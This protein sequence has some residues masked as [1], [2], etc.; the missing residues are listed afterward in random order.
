MEVELPAPPA[1][2]PAMEVELPAS[3]GLSFEEARPFDYAPE[4]TEV[5]VTDE[6]DSKGVAPTC[7][8]VIRTSSAVHDASSDDDSVASVAQVVPT[9]KVLVS[10]DEVSEPDEIAQELEV[11]AMLPDLVADT[12]IGDRAARPQL[13]LPSS[14]LYQHQPNIPWRMPTWKLHRG[15]DVCPC[16]THCGKP[17][18]DFLD[19]DIYRRLPEWPSWAPICRT[20]LLGEHSLFRAGVLWPSAA[21]VLCS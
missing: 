11:E 17:L 12:I 6:D 8:Q 16:A 4:P 7:K 9:A 13:A 5:A 21:N 10:D 3:A 19:A 14:G 20:C 18:K 1:P 2:A 15:H